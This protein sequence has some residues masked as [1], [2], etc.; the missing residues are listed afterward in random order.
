MYAVNWS[1]VLSAKRRLL[2][3]QGQQPLSDL[4]PQ[5]VHD[6]VAAAILFFVNGVDTHQTVKYL[7]F[8]NR[9]VLLYM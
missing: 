2:M 4:S 1:T 6:F 9:F 3:Q 7:V 5:L 8:V